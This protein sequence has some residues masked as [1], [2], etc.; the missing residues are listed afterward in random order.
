MEGTSELNRLRILYIYRILSEKTDDKHGITMQGLTEELERFGISAGR[1][2]IYQDIESLQLFGLK[3]EQTKGKNASYSLVKREFELAEL[4]LLADAVNSSRILTNEQCG[5]LIDKLRSLASENQ[6]RELRRQLRVNRSTSPINKT[7]FANIDLIYKA[8]AENK[9]IKFRY[10]DY[11][12]KKEKQYRDGGD[13]ICSPYELIWNDE[14][15][16]LA[17]FYPKYEKVINFRVDRMEF[18]RIQKESRLPLPD[19]FDMNEHIETGFSM[20]SGEEEMVSLRFKN[21]NKY[22]NVVLDRFGMDVSLIPDD[23]EHF[24]I[25]VRVKPAPPFYGWLFQFGNDVKVLTPSI[26]SKYLE[27]LHSVLEVNE[28]E[29]V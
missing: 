15:Y 12:I 19:G 24:H 21:T 28:D 8:I 2:A 9:Q 3:I 16:Y 20:F 7:I 27:Y 17:A 14:K 5:A 25:N 22:I 23:D 26:R 1:K 4:K 10:F 13:R 11:D 6:S 29:K 18:V